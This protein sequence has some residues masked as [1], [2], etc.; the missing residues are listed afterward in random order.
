MSL[1]WLC[2]RRDGQF[3]G[4][5]VFEAQFPVEAQLRAAVAGLPVGFDCECLQLSPDL[6][7]QIPKSLIDHV[8]S[9]EE[10]KQLKARIIPK[11]PAAASV[12]RRDPQK[13]S[14]S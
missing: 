7:R 14:A 12:H 4:A 11:K 8:L 5:A 1:Y 6:A 9:A 13:R 3:V 10:I 2:Y